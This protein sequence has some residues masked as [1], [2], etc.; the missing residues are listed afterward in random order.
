MKG[1]E[2][3]ETYFQQVGLAM[4]RE[5][6]ADYIDRIAVGLV[7][8][9][10][11]C[12]GFDDSLSRDHDWGPGFCIW[13]TRED[14]QIIGSK[15]KSAVAE[16]PQSFAGFGPRKKSQWGDERIGVFEISQF[17]RKFIGLDHLP[18]GLNEWL[19]IPENNLA[20]CTNGEVFFDPLKEFVRW[21]KAL[22]N[23][24]PEDARLKKIA[25]R[26]M[27]IGQAGQYNFPRCVQ[28]G[29]YFAAQYAETKFCADFMSLIFLLNRKYAPFYKWMHRAVKS[30]Q[31]LGEWTHRAV[32][33]LISE[34]EFEE[35]I[36][37][38]EEMCATVIKEL[39][40]QGL[41]D[42]DSSFMPDHGPTIQNR[43][44]D[45]ALREQNV[46]VG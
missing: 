32:A 33:S 46:W 2:L 7:G 29:E 37:R 35:K 11:E 3:S 8:D 30:L 9:G 26:C 24:Y 21:R 20:A 17:Y 27:T 10:S 41:S 18:S 38:V 22:L 14:H 4:L 45:N 16:L 31:I 25:A 28:R 15:L 19:I 1:L 13:L 23:F 44:V 34:S 40:R 43:I 42:I 39:I 36:K 5:K 6:F 12:F